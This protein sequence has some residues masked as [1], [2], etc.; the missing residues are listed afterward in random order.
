MPRSNNGNEVFKYLTSVKKYMVAS[1]THGST[2][3][4]GPTVVGDATLDLTAI[5]NF[6]SLDPVLIVSSA[7]TEF[8]QLTGT[9]AT[10]NSPI[11]TPTPFVHPTAATV[12]EMVAIDLGH[13][14]EAGVTLTGSLP[15]NPVNASTS[16][17]PIAYIPGQGSM[18]GSFNLRGYNNL[19]LATVFGMPEAETGA[20]TSGDPYT[21]SLLGTTIGTDTNIVFRASGVL[22]DGRTATVDFLGVT[23]AVNA[24]IAIGGSTPSVLAVQFNCT[25]VISRINT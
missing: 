2:T 25:G 11:A 13:L 15:I 16:R 12:T 10:T 21:L 14:D 20:G 6:T 8:N 23:P 18:G 24:N 1:G 3:L 5:T 17:V 9:L 22:I 7:G 4:S 19:N